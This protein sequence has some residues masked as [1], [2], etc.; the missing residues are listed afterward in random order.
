MFLSHN[1]GSS[2]VKKEHKYSREDHSKHKHKHHESKYHNYRRASRRDSSAE[3]DSKQH[4]HKSRLSNQKHSDKLRDCKRPRY[5]TRNRSRERS[6]SYRHKRYRSSSQ[7]S[8]RRQDQKTGKGS[9]ET[10]FIGEILRNS[11]THKSLGKKEEPKLLESV[12]KL[13]LKKKENDKEEGEITEEEDKLS[14][15]FTPPIYLLKINDKGKKP[16]VR[17]PEK[18][19]KKKLD[20]EDKTSPIKIVTQQQSKKKSVLELP[21]PPIIINT[22]PPVK[23]VHEASSG[24]IKSFTKSPNLSPKI[25]DM[26]PEHFKHRETHFKEMCSHLNGNPIV[27]SPEESFSDPTLPTPK[28]PRP[29]VRNRSQL[30]VA[31][32]AERTFDTFEIIQKVGEGTYGKVFKAM[33][34]QTKN[35]V[36][37]KYVRMEKESEGFPITGLREIKI[38]RGLQHPNIVQLREIV[39]DHSD[40]KGTYLVFEYMHHD[41]LGLLDDKS[42]V[43]NEVTIFQIFQ[44]LLE[45]LNFCHQRKILHRDLKCS[46]ILVNDKGEVKLA[47]F[48]LGRQYVTDRPF[49]NKVISLWYRPIELLL[50]EEKYG[51]AVDIWSL[52][53]IFGELFQRRP[54][55]PFTTELDMINA[56]FNLCGTPTKNS[57]PEVKYLPGY[58][59]L[60]SKLCRRMLIESFSKVIPS[61]AL[62]LFDKMLCLNPAKRISTEDALK[63]NWILVMREKKQTEPLQLPVD[64]DCH[65]LNVKMRRKK[66]N[67]V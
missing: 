46:N 9:D 67:V 24:E 23:R 48:G 3:L 62:D 42:M 5:Y 25:P 52:A 8:N 32:F 50:G 37:M 29:T 1:L 6:N 61:L 47:D 65:E 64:R 20:I 30:T 63:S 15:S 41:L 17:E 58:R 21:M 11:S 22:R 31:D 18:V 16:I 12:S 38:L 43:F 13:L 45:G 56:I 66:L 27:I 2:E 54:V 40:R 36:A 26:M 51:P 7:D 35:I 10:T 39:T 49:T 34:L 14:E 53:C 33:D 4:M 44:Q 28:L 59:T 57:W 19:E 60:K 55:F